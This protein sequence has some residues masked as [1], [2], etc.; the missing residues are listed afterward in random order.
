MSKIEGPSSMPFCDSGDRLR[1]ASPRPVY[2]LV[3]WLLFAHL[4]PRSSGRYRCYA[5]NRPFRKG[6]GGTVWWR[7][8]NSMSLRL[9]CELAGYKRCR[10]RS[11]SAD[12]RLSSRSRSLFCAHSRE[13]CNTPITC[14]TPRTRGG[15][16][17]LSGHL[18]RRATYVGRTFHRSVLYSPDL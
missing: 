3:R 8:L 18:P 13:L 17:P 6:A 15:I 10:A 4:V 14:Q 9:V 12:T 1:G 2:G 7:S 16:H 5:V 11:S